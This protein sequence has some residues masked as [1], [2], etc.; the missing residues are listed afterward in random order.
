MWSLPH[1]LSDA[2]FQLCVNMLQTRYE[3]FPAASS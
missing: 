3:H 2:L 1:Y